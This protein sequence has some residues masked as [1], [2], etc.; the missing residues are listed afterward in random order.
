MSTKVFE[1]K[2]K[3]SSDQIYVIEKVDSS[4]SYFEYVDRGGFNAFALAYDIGRLSHLEE[5]GVD[6]RKI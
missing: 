5:Y 1:G 2:Y 4:G 6:L 3:N